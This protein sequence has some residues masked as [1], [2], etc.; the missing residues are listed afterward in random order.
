MN[1][2]ILYGL[3]AVIVVVSALN[4]ILV[5]SK[6][7]EISANLI[8]VKEDARPADIEIT[9]LKDSSC[10]DCFDVDKVLSD[11]K[12]KNFN[13]LKEE[14]TDP[15]SEK[16]KELVQKFGIT[17]LPTL[18]VSG[19]IKKPNIENYFKGKWESKDLDGKTYAVYKDVLPPYVDYSTKEIVG[20]VLLTHIIDSSC[21]DCSDLSA[22][23][24][25][26][27]KEA[28]VV[29]SQE[30]TLEYKTPEAQSLISRFGVER[31][32]A[33]IISKN[34]LDYPSAQ[35]IWAG[36]GAVEKE[37]FFALHG[38]SP[39]YRDIKTDQIKGL[40]TAIYL[41]DKSCKTC[42]DIEG[43]KNIISKVIGLTVKEEKETD[44]SSDE[45][46]AFIERYKVQKI[47]TVLLSAEAN[48]YDGFADAFV[49]V[50]TKETDGWFVIRNPQIFGN[51]KD[52]ATGQEVAVNRGGQPQA[53]SG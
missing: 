20:K 19:E 13:V 52:L 23:I 47:P 14:E 25:Y 36:L 24:S 16:G 1:H 8:K 3:I 40:V 22:V 29:F 43:V 7:Q 5:T 30:K 35:E 31:V 26:L 21:D 50:G 4:L 39:P 53:H 44:I 10:A 37:G 48:D 33:L 46:K 32:P 41:V 45:G 28:G 6:T 42:Y 11:L 18:L 34:I 38:Q 51:F 49:Q 9:K 17:K 15:Y 12:S 2:N 27:K